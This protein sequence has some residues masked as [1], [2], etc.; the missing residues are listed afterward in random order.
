MNGVRPK[1]S[2][3]STDIPQEGRLP[4]LLGSPGFAGGTFNV[5]F[6]EGPLAWPGL[7]A[8][9]LPLAA[10]PAWVLVMAHRMLRRDWRA[11]THERQREDRF[12]LGRNS[13]RR[14]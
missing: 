6:K 2:P 8:W 13:P 5:F 14:V 4:Q 12:V 1:I 7:L 9:W 10:F 11:R 3:A